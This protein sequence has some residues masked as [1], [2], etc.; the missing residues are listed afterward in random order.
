MMK[1]LVAELEGGADFAELAKEKSTGPSGPNG[2]SWLVW[3]RHD[4]HAI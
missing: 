4:G 3:H 2:R 1:D